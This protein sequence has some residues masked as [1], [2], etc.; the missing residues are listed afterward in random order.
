MAK[1]IKTGIQ[2]NLNDNFSAKIKGASGAV[3]SFADQSKT[4]I[5]GLD[6]VFSGT[7]AK[8]GA[9]GVGLSL[10]AA[11]KDMIDLDYRLTRIGLTAKM[12]GDQ[13]AEAKQKIYNAALETRTDIEAGVSAFDVIMTKTGDLKFAEENFINIAKAAQATGESGEALGGALSAL[14]GQHFSSADIL[15]FLDTASAISDKGAF[16]LGVF[17]Q[18]GEKLVAQ[19]STNI[20]NSVDD[21]SNGLKD[22]QVVLKGVGDPAQSVT[23]YISLLSELNKKEDDLAKS[24]IKVRDAQT[25]K[26]RNVYDIMKDIKALTDRKGNTRFIYDMFGETARMGV[27]GFMEYGEEL[28][29][30]FDKI[31]DATG[32]IDKK[33]KI[34]NGTFKSSLQTLQTSFNKFADANMGKVLEPLAKTLNWLAEDPARFD[35]VFRSIRKG[36]IAIATVKIGAGAIQIFEQIKSRG[37]GLKLPVPGLGGTPPLG[38]GIGGA[39]P[40][41]VTNWV[42]SGGGTGGGSGTGYGGAVAGGG[43]VYTPS[44]AHTVDNMLDARRSAAVFEADFAN[45]EANSKAMRGGAIGAGVVQTAT[46]AISSVMDAYDEIEKIN[47]DENI[48]KEEKSKAKGGA[49]GAAVGMTVGTGAGILAGS[50]LAAKIGAMIGTAVAPGI[51]TAI[52][53]AIGLAGGALVGWLGGK[54]GRAVGEGLGGALAD[55]G[56]SLKTEVSEE[57]LRRRNWRTSFRKDTPV[58]PADMLPQQIT[59]T[60]NITIKPPEPVVV[61]TEVTFKDDRTE[62][63][64]RRHGGGGAVSHGYR[65][66]TG[67]TGDARAVQ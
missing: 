45:R 29:T 49:I 51:G 66:Q 5:Q 27:L 4:A 37:S 62:V 25:G 23:A 36:L 58:F 60:N 52:G 3:R 42:G 13:V 33:V 63:T 19:I 38:A 10:G 47:A 57:T 21:I 12:S 18:Y 24:G 6:K 55:D 65:Y 40:V 8:L 46:V 15:K 20:G 28:Y 2:I 50:L 14:A 56:T 34:M 30:E 43:G 7:A 48:T 11:T 44:N 16:T 64:M 35:A 31:G 41:Y 61:G 17:S 54:A 59:G 1:E 22:M 9:L 32:E 39:L 53:G 26:L 67:K